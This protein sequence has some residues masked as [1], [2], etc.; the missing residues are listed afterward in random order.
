M[1]KNET[2]V[3]EIK[4]SA[5]MKIAL[6]TKVQETSTAFRKMQS[7]YLKSLRN[8]AFPME[9][10]SSPGPYGTSGGY[11]PVAEDEFDVVLSQNALQQSSML[12]TSEDESL[13]QREH[14]ITKIAQGILELADIFK[15]L[16]SMV[17]DQGTLLDR[18]DYNVETMYTNVKAADK[19]L[20]Q[21]THYQKRTQKCKI[22][23]LLILIIVGLI[24]VLVVKPK[25][26]SSQSQPQPPQ[27]PQQEPPDGPNS[28]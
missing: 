9:R 19:E 22:I 23:L 28:R 20:I 3:A 17:I 7:S 15:D 4:M 18:I 1:T 25:K 24:I 21:A 26:H 2:S 27:P 16:Q 12:A 10:V 13:R 5:N 11:D 8:D 6:A 14:E